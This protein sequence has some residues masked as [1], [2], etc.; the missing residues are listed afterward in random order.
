[1]LSSEDEA[2]FVARLA[3]GDG[4]AVWARRIDSTCHSIAPT[5]D[6]G[7]AASIMY[8]DAPLVLDDGGA[9][10]VLQ[11]GSARLSLA[12]IRF[13]ADGS[14]GWARRAGTAD[15]L[16]ENDLEVAPD[17]AIYV[18]GGLGDNADFGGDMPTGTE[19][20]SI[21]M[22]RLTPD[23]E[24][25]WV[26]GVTSLYSHGVVAAALDDGSAMFA[27][28]L[29]SPGD[30]GGIEL[31]PNPSEDEYITRYDAT[32][33]PMWARLIDGDD[34]N[35]TLDLEQIPGPATGA[36]L[37]GQY[38]GTFVIG[39]GAGALAAPDVGDSRSSYVSSLAPDGQPRWL[40]ITADKLTEIT[41]TAAGGAVAA[42][43]TSS[44]T[45]GHDAVVVRFD[46]GGAIT[47]R[48]VSESSAGT[49]ASN[50]GVVALG[51]RDV[52]VAGTFDGTISLAPGEED[53]IIL[54]APSDRL[55]A[56]VVR[57]RR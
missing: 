35:W 6:G 31:E 10:I 13:E 37:V 47:W 33:E 4:S 12:V 43:N 23:G 20:G 19:R 51:D 36:M 57:F 42:G 39:S 45:P 30:F 22:L 7:V 52:A 5:P 14:I 40:E 1:M 48:H 55:D 32:G 15:H 24:H 9:E 25:D 26:R 34:Q 50:H 56:Y 21:Y 18:T 11:P 27:G 44:G 2:C 8:I 3:A 53:N 29:G 16:Y 49:G 46:S 54:E 17:G 38:Y 28:T 41:P